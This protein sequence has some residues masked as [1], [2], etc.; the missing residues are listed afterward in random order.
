MEKWRLYLILAGIVMVA[1]NLDMMFIQGIGVN[2]T[3]TIGV[4]ASVVFIFALF[5]TRKK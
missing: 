1:Y 4:I 5:F 2:N 3:N